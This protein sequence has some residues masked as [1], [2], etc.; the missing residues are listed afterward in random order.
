MVSGTGKSSNTNVTLLDAT[1]YQVFFSKF[2]YE[3]TKAFIENPLLIFSRH[4]E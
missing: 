3:L 4:R 1:K 2:V